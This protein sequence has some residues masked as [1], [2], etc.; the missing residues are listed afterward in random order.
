MNREIKYIVIHSTQ[1]RKEVSIESIRNS[2]KTNNQPA[3]FHCIIDSNGH[4]ARILGMNFT[5]AQ[6][7]PQNENCFHI[8]VIGGYAGTDTRTPLQ[9][10]ILFEKIEEVKKLFPTAMVIGAGEYTGETNPFF[11]VES[12]MNFYSTHREDWIFLEVAEEE[13]EEKCLLED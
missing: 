1:T 13:G 9:T 11:D 8:A 7:V 6:N 3:K 12:W 2:W 10:H 5:A 4:A